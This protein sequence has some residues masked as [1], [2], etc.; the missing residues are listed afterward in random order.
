MVIGWLW[1]FLKA[2]KKQGEKM[3]SFWLFVALETADQSGWIFG[4]FG[5][6]SDSE[7]LGD[8]IAQPFKRVFDGNHQEKENAH[9]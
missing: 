6:F 4:I 5:L 2:L 1:H 8:L 7:N 3:F 9:H